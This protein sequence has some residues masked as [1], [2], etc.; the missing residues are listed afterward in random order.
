MASRK[1]RGWLWVFPIIIIAGALIFLFAYFSALIG[2]G[3]ILA[4]FGGSALYED[5]IFS[6]MVIPIAVTIIIV[7]VLLAVWAVAT[8]P[9][10]D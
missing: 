1:G 3:S 7:I 6:N 2:G 5:F 9:G 8:R 10:R 4:L